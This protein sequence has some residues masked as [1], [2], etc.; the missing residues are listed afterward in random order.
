MRLVPLVALAAVV[1][2][3]LAPSASAIDINVVPI[4]DALVGEPYSF[5]LDGEE[6]CRA[7]YRFTVDGQPFPPGL[8]IGL[9]D[10]II[11]GIPT[12]PG[13]YTFYVKLED[14]C[15]FIFSQGLFTMIVAPQLVITSPAVVAP[16]VGQPFATQ[17][18]ASGGGTQEWAVT[19]GSL[20]DNVTLS[21]TGLLSGVLSTPGAT[22]VTV[23]VSDPKRKGTQQ[24]V[25]GASTL[26]VTQPSLP[27]GVVLKDFA[28]TLA[29]TGGIGPYRWAVTKG[30]LPGGLELDPA[31]GAL[32][33]RPRQ[34]GAFPLDLT[35]TD[36]TGAIKTAS[37]TLTISRRLKVRRPTAEAGKV[38][39]RYALRFESRGGVGPY[40]W[41]LEKGAL[42]G[43]LELDAKTGAVT[44]TPTEA[45]RFPIIVSVTDANG[46]VA[47]WWLPIRIGR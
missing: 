16:P 19:E 1:A 10:G 45:G 4:P 11:S 42:P 17:L 41:E 6:G 14:D 28:A 5:Q 29:A 34:A 24:L 12:V 30:D 44:G 43:G 7:S 40:S 38:G 36:V 26:V 33:G 25:I 2:G 35:V 47:R 23:Q 8:T 27:T 13:T 31:S 3:L 37:V 39:S 20:P 32:T 46:N 18:T 15:S 22:I 9:R 21:R